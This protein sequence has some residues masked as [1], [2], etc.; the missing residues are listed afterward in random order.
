MI[1]E[2]TEAHFPTLQF[3]FTG[4]WLPTHELEEVDRQHTTAQTDTANSLQQFQPS[5]VAFRILSCYLHPAVITGRTLLST[6]I[7]VR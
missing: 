5:V 4:V 3:S 6:N 2:R 7:W 1:E